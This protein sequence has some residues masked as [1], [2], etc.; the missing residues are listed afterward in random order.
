MPWWNQPPQSP[1]DST[2]FPLQKWFANANA[3]ECEIRPK[4]FYGE[5]A[6]PA[7]SGGASIARF[8]PHNGNPELNKFFL[9][10]FASLFQNIA[11]LTLREDW[12]YKN[13]IS[14][15]WRNKRKVKNWQWSLYL[16]WSS[17]KHL[18]QERWKG[19]IGVARVTNG[20]KS[21]RPLGRTHWEASVGVPRKIG[22]E[23][24]SKWAAWK[25]PM[26]WTG[27]T[28]HTFSGAEEVLSA[29]IWPSG[30]FGKCDWD[31]V[32]APTWLNATWMSE[33]CVTLVCDTFFYTSAIFGPGQAANTMYQILTER[34]VIICVLCQ[35]IHP[36]KINSVTISQCLFVL[37]SPSK[38]E[39]GNFCLK[40]FRP[41]SCP[42]PQW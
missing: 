33:A 32:L 10:C 9:L 7:Q 34:V 15:I 21:I 5:G 25:N 41:Q 17:S 1:V 42:E 36:F 12:K 13:V 4:A 23:M 8:S 38:A 27:S 26:P 35:R 20:I 11:Q 30:T 37:W 24:L 40:L 19:R 2:F 6:K 31:S 14:Y 39:G 28:C 18:C 3:G 29:L 16:S 22:P